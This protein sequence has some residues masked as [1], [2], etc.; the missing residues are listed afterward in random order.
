MQNGQGTL[1]NALTAFAWP[2][3]A[4]ADLACCAHLVTYEKN[5]IIFHS[6]EA[7]D[8]VYVLVSGEVKLQYDTRDP[9]LLVSIARAGQMIG[10]FASDLGA[11]S[12]GRPEQLFTA[13]ALSRSKVAIIPTARV[14]QGLQQLRPEQL[15]RVL[16]SNREQ[17]VRL[18]CRLLDYLSMG[19][20]RRLV[21]A[22]AEIAEHFSVS[23]ARGRLITVRLS[24]DDLAALVGASRPM[25]S[26]HLK[27]LESDG[28]LTRDQ[29]RYRILPAPGNERD[30][31]G[32]LQARY[33][34]EGVRELDRRPRRKRRLGGD[35][36]ELRGA[37]G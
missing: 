32:A 5:S 17:W 23:D 30:G 37:E 26:K 25:V 8:L 33:S 11:A 27:K 22:L 31:N 35:Q 29:G 20:R 14:A 28:V 15:V 4:A 12:N 1:L 34:A 6:G 10:V 16:E 21:H 18:S 2:A 9:H 24:H 3:K 36:E 13:Q 7:A 19:I